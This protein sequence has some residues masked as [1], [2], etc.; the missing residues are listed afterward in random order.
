M[1]IIMVNIDQFQ[2]LFVARPGIRGAERHER[3]NK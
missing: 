1:K 3:E 2:H